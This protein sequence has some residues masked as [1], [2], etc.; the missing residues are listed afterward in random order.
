MF[1]EKPQTAKKGWWNNSHLSPQVLLPPGVAAPQ[2]RWE[3]PGEPPGKRRVFFL[4]PN[5]CNQD[6]YLKVPHDSNSQGIFQPKVFSTHFL[7]GVS[8]GEWCLMFLDA[9]ANQ[10]RLSKTY[11]YNCLQVWLWWIITRPIDFVMIHDGTYF[12]PSPPQKMLWFEFPFHLTDLSWCLKVSL[13]VW[14]SWMLNCSLVSWLPPSFCWVMW[15]GPP[16]QAPRKFRLGEWFFG[17]RKNSSLQGIPTS[18][19]KR[20]LGQ[21]LFSRWWFQI[22]F[23]FAPIWERFPVWLIFF[24]WVETT[25]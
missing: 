17:W 15:M 5:G 11:F 21:R 22:C 25:N 20:P 10:P 1:G 9:K 24:N 23:I 16:T 6:V 2:A 14:E 13:P 18:L 12:S 7:G 4:N 3:T 19:P 8:V